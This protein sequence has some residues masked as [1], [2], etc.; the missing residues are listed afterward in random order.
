MGL[1]L[2]SLGPDIAEMADTPVR[3]KNRDGP[4]AALHNGAQYNRSR[5]NCRQENATTDRPQEN[6]PAHH[7][8]A[9]L[10]AAAP[11]VTC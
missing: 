2:Q 9:R 6:G 3:G 1:W 7:A 8:P 5:R 11:G 4:S 10:E